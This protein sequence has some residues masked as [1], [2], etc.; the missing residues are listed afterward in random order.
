MNQMWIM[1]W[2]LAIGHSAWVWINAYRRGSRAAAPRSFPLTTPPLISILIPAWNEIAVIARTIRSLQASDHPRWEAILIAGG[3]DG[4][5]TFARELCADDS[6]FTII[7]QPPRGKN[8]ALNLG[9]AHAQGEIIVLL[10]ADTEVDRAWLAHLAA[11]IL[12]G[13]SAATT[14]C[15]PTQTTWVSMIYVMEK[16]AAYAV[17]GNVI[18]SGGGGIALRRALIDQL[19]GFPEDV[20]VGVDWDLDQRVKQLGIQPVFANMA[21]IETPL[22]H[23]IREY[24]R[25]ETRWRRAHV[26]SILR[27]HDWSGLAFYAAAFLFW[28]APLSL[29]TPFAP[30]VPILWCWFLLRRFSLSI[31]LFAAT[32]DRIWLRYCLTPILLTPIDFIAAIMGVSSARR[33]EIF[34]KGFRPPKG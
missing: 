24:L 28:I 31:E 19:G 17:R 16:C 25:T 5:E 14:I 9:L 12:C 2:A 29:L 1:L 26:Q 10:D 34:F 21:R 32:R 15:Y 3:A 7:A 30:I 18:L 33:K 27:H 8:A 20:T 13:E 22:A 23:T 4:T 11:P 6:R